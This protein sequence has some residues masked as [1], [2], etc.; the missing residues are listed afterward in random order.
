MNFELNPTIERKDIQ[1]KKVYSDIFCPL[2]LMWVGFFGVRF[3]VGG[4]GKI[5]LVRVMLETWHLVR[6]HKKICSFR[7]YT[8]FLHQDFLS[9]ADVSIFWL[10]SAFF[11][12][13]SAFT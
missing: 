8:F 12:K 11:A 1:A 10:M 5:K 4:G 3:E 6:N 2:T 7:K 9:F 13:N